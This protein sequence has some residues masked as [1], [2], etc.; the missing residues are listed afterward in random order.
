M[1]CSICG[2]EA[3][4]LKSIDKSIV[5]RFTQYGS[6]LFAARCKNCLNEKEKI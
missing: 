1:K 2:A 4:Y 5:N 3:S 6:E